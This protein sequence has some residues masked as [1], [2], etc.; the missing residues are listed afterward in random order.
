MEI[1][2]DVFKS[3]KPILLTDS[4]RNIGSDAGFVVTG[5]VATTQEFVIF[6]T[7][8]ASYGTVGSNETVPASPPYEFTIDP[9]FRGSSLAVDVTYAANGVEPRTD[10]FFLTVYAPELDQSGL[11]VSDGEDG[12]L[13]RREGSGTCYLYPYEHGQ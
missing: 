10:Q 4:V 8:A 2:T 12:V 13:E 1:L 5:A 11:T 9:E 3:E 6:C 7:V